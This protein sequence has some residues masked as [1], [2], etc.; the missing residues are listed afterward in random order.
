MLTSRTSMVL[1]GTFDPN[2]NVMPSSGCT[3]ITSCVVRPAHR[4]WSRRTADA[5]PVL[6]TMAISVTL[7]PNRFP[8]RR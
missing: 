6:K 3:R 4:S 2:R 5:A 8:V 7:R 1:P